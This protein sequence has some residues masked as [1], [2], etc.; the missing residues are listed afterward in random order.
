MSCN[1]LCLRPEADFLKLGVTPPEALSIRYL[2]PDSP[3]LRAAFLEARAL[4]IPAVGPKLPPDLFAGTPIELVQVTG[5]GIDRVDAA[6]LK[7]LNIAVANVPGGSSGA[8]A[9]YAVSSALNLLRRTTWADRELRKGNYVAAR[10]RMLAENL[11]GLEGLTVGV[12]GLGII[13]LA[14][15][16]AFHDMRSHIVYHD[17]AV[18]DPKLAMA[19]G[20]RA[21]PL[22][23]LLRDSDIV[24]LHVPLLASTESLIADAEFQQMKAGAIL[25][26]AARGGVVDEAALARSLSSGHLAAAAVDV[27][28]SEPPAADNPLL[29]LEDEVAGRL[30]LTPHLAGVTRQSWVFLFQTAW[31]NVEAALLR[32]E[33][34]ANRVF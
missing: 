24:T 3:D 1:V 15:A 22:A 33:P 17:P 34:P 12:V 9:E 31:Q 21:L 32:G 20:A 4:L 8:I 14:V 16:K 13:G 6:A 10:S 29:M 28:S 25:I 18:R 23:D 26:N 7:S 11:S 30:L 5:A 27:F 2:S 19:L